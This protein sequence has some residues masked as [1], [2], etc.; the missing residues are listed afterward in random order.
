MCIHTI[1]TSDVVEAVQEAGAESSSGYTQ[2]NEM[3]Y[4]DLPQAAQCLKHYVHGAEQTL[5][6]VKWPVAAS[7]R[8]YALLLHM[9]QTI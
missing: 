5:A 8:T 7:E 3:N 4:E 2:Q 1:K 9:F 6:A